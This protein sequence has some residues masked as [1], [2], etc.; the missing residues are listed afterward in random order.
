MRSEKNPFNRDPHSVPLLRFVIHSKSLSSEILS[1]GTDAYRLVRLNNFRQINVISLP[2]THDE[3]RRVFVANGIA[4]TDYYTDG[5]GIGLKASDGPLHGV[6]NKTPSNLWES[7]AVGSDVTLADIFASNIWDYL[8]VGRDDPVHAEKA[9][10]IAA[11]IVTAESAIDIVRILMTSHGFYYITPQ[12]PQVNEGFYYLYRFKTLYKAYQR[13]W[14]IAAYAGKGMSERLSDQLG[15]LGRRLEFLCRAYDKIGFFSLKTA[16][17]DTLDN[18]LYHLAYFVMLST[19]VFDDLA[20]IIEEFYKMEVKNRINISLRISKDK[21]GERKLGKFYKA[22][23]L[24]AP[25]L[26]ALLATETTQ[27]QIDVFYP[28]RDSFMHRELFE[29]VQFSDSSIHIHNKN[30]I[31]LN[32]EAAKSLLQEPEVS[33]CIASHRPFLD[34]FIF[35]VCAQEILTELV[36]RVLLSIDWDSIVKTLP[37]EV[38]VKILES[39]DTFEK[40]VGKAI[41]WP[42]E[43][44]YF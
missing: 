24:K 18:Q 13:A 14:T 19:G 30:L 25:N 20:H 38:Q 8:V 22:L 6:T 31:K 44:W 23:Q 26:Y 43:P 39:Y 37:S 5:E 7:V 36:N 3:L 42:D 40:G 1:A 27:R 41:G 32:E 21:S 9:E 12:G 17:W 28:L 4:L 16:D 35:V 10:K 34:P 29:G 33:P 11:Q 2:T 15:S